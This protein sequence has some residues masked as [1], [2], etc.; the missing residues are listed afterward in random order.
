MI[1]QRFAVL[2][3]CLLAVLPA[4]GQDEFVIIVNTSVSNT[5]MYQNTVQSIFLGKKTEWDDG[6][7]IVPVTLEAGDAQRAF[8]R[9]IVKK[10]PRSFSTYWIS[11]LYTG[12]AIPPRSFRSEEELLE[13]VQTIEGT[14][15][16]VPSDLSLEGKDCIKKLNVV[17]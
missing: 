15:G 8:M 16:F 9:H 10:T 7:P 12:K 2:C 14:I 13:F 11:K 6:N 1:W 17:Y 3:L 4:I 5:L